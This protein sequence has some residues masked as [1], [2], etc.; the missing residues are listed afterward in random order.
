MGLNPENLRNF[1]G[2]LLSCSLQPYNDVRP[3]LSA[4]QICHIEVGH[5]F[6]AVSLHE[7]R[8]ILDK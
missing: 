2:G 7:P 8:Y 3:S 5:K 6:S 1:Q 4:R